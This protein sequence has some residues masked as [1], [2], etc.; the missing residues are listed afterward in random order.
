MIAY[1]EFSN[2]VMFMYINLA[3]RIEWYI[4]LYLILIY[5]FENV[6]QSLN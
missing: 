2:I 6:L 5:L 4:V 3:K 1:I